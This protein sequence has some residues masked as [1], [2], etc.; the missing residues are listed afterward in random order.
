MTVPRRIAMV[1]MH[2]S[3]L[4]TPGSGDAGGMNVYVAETARRLAARGVG[5]DVFTR[6]TS[7]SERE[8]DPTLDGV[9]VRHV[10]AGPYDGLRKND[11]PGQLCAFTSGVLRVEASSP[12]GWYDLVHTHYWLS[13]QVGMSTARRWGVPLVHSMHTMAKVKNAHLAQGDAPEPAAR[14]RGEEEVVAG[15]QALVANTERERDELVSL[16]DADPAR[17]AVV[18]PGVDLDVFTPD[19]GARARLGIPDDTI[20]LVYAGRI[21]PLKGPDVL[22]RAV[23]VLLARRPDLRSRLRVAVLGGD[24][25]A[26]YGEPGFLRHLAAGLGVGDVFHW[27]EHL[28]RPDLARWFAAAD[29]VA[30]PSHNESFGLVAL[31]ALACGTPVVATNVGGL[32]LAVGDGGVLVDDH[33][34]ARWADALERVALDRDLRADL[35]RRALAHAAGFSWEATVDRLL[36]VYAQATDRMALAR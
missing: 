22:V 16:Y 25:G 6:A 36:D 15:A 4:A 12:E 32:P 23:A 17:V 29:A 24:S 20:L 13:G 2:T 30:V 5:V 7:A 1:S 3:P 27:G 11:L 18:P 19:A 28:D 14:V 31:E 9:L 34:P 35:A 10:I 26:S 21:Q 8:D 33:E